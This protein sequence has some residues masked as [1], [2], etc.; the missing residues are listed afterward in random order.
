MATAQTAT[1]RVK[2][3]YDFTNHKL[4]TTPP[5][6]AFKVGD[7]IEFFSDQ[8][9]VHILLE[10]VDAYEP[11]EFRQGDPPVLKTK[12]GNGMIWCGGTYRNAAGAKPAEVTIDPAGMNW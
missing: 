12:P 2:L 8:G 6:P 11:N 1:V 4:T 5:K 10:P 3:T 7:K 9:Q